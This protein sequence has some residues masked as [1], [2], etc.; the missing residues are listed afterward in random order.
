MRLAARIGW[1]NADL[2]GAGRIHVFILAVAR[3]GARPTGSSEEMIDP[4][5]HRFQ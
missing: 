5:M 2:G 1:E 3:K 4:E